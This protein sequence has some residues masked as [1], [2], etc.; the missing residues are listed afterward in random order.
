LDDEAR[1]A[2]W[3]DAGDRMSVAG[4]ALDRRRPPQRLQRR[5]ED[6]DGLAAIFVAHRF[7][8]SAP[9][10]SPCGGQVRRVV[11]EFKR[12]LDVVSHRPRN[13]RRAG[14]E[15]A[16]GAFAIRMVE[17]D[18]AQL[19]QIAEA[20]LSE[21]RPIE[22]L[23]FLV[24]LARASTLRLCAASHRGTSAPCSVPSLESRISATTCASVDRVI[25]AS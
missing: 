24:L 17:I 3:R 22:R 21:D 19:D 2:R 6:R 12:D 13:E 5:L 25:V 18:E 15:E 10:G 9:H 11:R 4:L 14:A 8:L 1:R 20:L 16:V 7:T 23:T